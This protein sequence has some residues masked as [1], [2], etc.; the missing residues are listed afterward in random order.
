MSS[1][2]TNHYGDATIHDQ[3]DTIRYLYESMSYDMTVCIAPEKVQKALR[4]HI[5]GSC[6]V[7]VRSVND[8]V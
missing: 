2:H 8:I 4:L 7:L 1:A 6:V 3:I 5:I